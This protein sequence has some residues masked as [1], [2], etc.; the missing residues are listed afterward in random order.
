MTVI[1]VPPFE[2]YIDGVLRDVVDVNF[3]RKVMDMG[4]TWSE[5]HQE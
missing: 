5:V 1:A 2:C 4:I 3:V